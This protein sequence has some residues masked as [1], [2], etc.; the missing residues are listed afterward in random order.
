[1]KIIDKIKD[2]IEHGEIFYSFEYFPPRT[3]A[4]AVNLVSRVDRMAQSD[5]LFVDVTWGAGGGNPGDVNAET[6]S[7]G[8][9]TNVLN[10]CNVDTMLH[11]TC[12][13]FTKDQITEFLRIAKDNGIHN[14]LALRGDP[15]PG[16]DWKAVKDGFAYAADLVRHIRQ[17]FGDFFG[18]AVAGYPNGHPDSPTY[19]EDLKYL[20]EKVDAG[21][22][23]IITQLFLESEVFIKYVADCRKLGI[24]CPILPGILPIQEYSSLRHLTKLSKVV[25]PQWMVDKI[26]AIKDDDRAI[27]ELGVEL[28]ANMCREVLESGAAPGIHIYTLNREYAGM[29]I[30]KRLGLYDPNKQKKRS[31]PWRKVSSNHRR[32]S[33]DVRPIFWAIRPKSYLLRTKEWDE[34]PNGRWGD[35]SSPAY[36]ELENHHIFS[37][38]VPK[39][40]LLASWGQSLNSW[41]DVADVF[42]RYLSKDPVVQ[43]LPWNDDPLSLESDLIIN[44]LRLVNRYG[45]LT[46]NSQ[47]AVNGVSSNDK[48]HGWGGDGGFVYQKAYIEFFISPENLENLLLVLKDFPHVTY[49]ATNKA[50]KERRSID[51]DSPM[52]VTWGV[53]P[54]KEVIQPTVVD[55]VSFRF[56]KDEAFALW[57]RWGHLYEEG[58]TS[59]GVI[60]SIRDTWYLTC[61]VDNDY[62]RSN[63]FDVF[64]AYIARFGYESVGSP[65][66][67]S[68]PATATA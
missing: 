3:P 24:T 68:E 65:R 23:L 57:N 31:L 28:A 67:A 6:S 39:E 38:Q 5:P 33:E 36:G 35:S 21:A 48:V 51:K 40:K 25:M 37:H 54:N 53:F 41:A 63:L 62:V 34:F 14:I 47:P 32:T 27:R 11:M 12:T 52:A 8:V 30:I 60:E 18:I 66:Q 1:M 55:P 61:L 2:K 15:R 59:R 42:V 49:I 9:A 22:D 64:T 20:K 16:E 58:T 7:M 56:W 45:V 29:E 43:M 50:G 13:E 26:E 17:E 19:E 4:G 44:H 10:M 46:I